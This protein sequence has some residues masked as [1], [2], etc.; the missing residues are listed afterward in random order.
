MKPTENKNI[1]HLNSNNSSNITFDNSNIYLKH[2]K[3]HFKS[4]YSNNQSNAY[5]NS[6]IFES[7]FSTNPNDYLTNTSNNIINN[8]SS[9]ISNINNNNNIYL[10]E[11]KQIKTTSSKENLT[12]EN[13]KSNNDS[14]ITSSNTHRR[15]DN[16]PNKMEIFYPEFKGKTSIPP[17]HRLHPEN[18]NIISCCDKKINAKN[19]NNLFTNYYLIPPKLSNKFTINYK[20]ENIHVR[21]SS[22][23]YIE[24]TK[25]IILLNYRLKLK[26]EAK[27][28]IENNI[29]NQIKE[30]DFKMEEIKK[31]KNELEDNFI[32]KYYTHLKQLQIGLDNERITNINLMLK[33]SSLNKEVNSLEGIIQKKKSYIN[34]IEKW[35]KFLI[36]LK[37]K[38]NFSDVKK[39]LKENLNENGKIFNDVDE[40]ED[41]FVNEENKNIFLLKRYEQKR[42]EV[43]NLKDERDLYEKN[44]NKIT[45][46]LNNEI[47]EKE[48]L[49]T[50]MRLRY[51]SLRKLK[52]K[53]LSNTNNNQFQ[54]KK[55]SS[56]IKNPSPTNNKKL[57]LK[58]VQIY[59][60]IYNNCFREDIFI[61]NL[62]QIVNRNEKMI[63]MMICIELMC[64]Y[65]IGKFN[66]YKSEKKFSKILIEIQSKI[67]FE[68][69][70][71]KTIEK[72]QEEYKKYLELKKQID[73]RNEKVYFIPKK[74]VDNYPF[75]IFVKPKNNKNNEK[76]VNKELT[77]ED[78]LYDLEED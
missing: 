74:K 12:K 69:K 60:N 10:T 14:L 48:K 26:K 66:E 77:I 25:S 70:R 61:Y 34:N 6:S 41:I 44:E 73:K 78:F 31:A 43:E 45:S 1:N 13:L 28:T 18:H 4:I 30:L 35:L 2:K 21:D 57:Y 67:D 16:D 15:I 7:R 68:H 56:S 47:L 17:I 42:L 39:A 50:L 36:L 23:D 53:I 32:I 20:K 58:I 75:N 22:Y 9:Q 3:N 62:K 40:F 5:L 76:N 63:K 55:K 54:P 8:N 38:K 24:K 49:H 37:T 59:V 52:G 46:T 29:K 51:E 71:Q 27:K 33:L 19:L 64:N 65:L 72:K 11:T